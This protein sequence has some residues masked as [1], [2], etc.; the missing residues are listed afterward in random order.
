MEGAESVGWFSVFLGWII[1][2]VQGAMG[3]LW[4]LLTIQNLAT[5]VGTGFGIW[6]TW[7]AREANLYLRFER[8][9][10]RYEHQ[11]VKARSD[12]LDVMNRPGPGVLIRTPLFMTWKLRAVLQRHKWHPT[13]LWPIGQTV[14]RQLERALVTCNRK[15]SAHLGRLS[16]FREQVASARLVQGSLA[17]AR[18]AGARQLDERQRLDGEALDHFRSV[19]AIPGHQDDLGA[20]ELISHQL[21]RV[22]QRSQL[23]VSSYTRMIQILEQ[24]SASTS[25]N[26]ALARAKRCLASLIYSTSPGIA[27]RMLSDAI[28]LLTELGP[29]PDRDFLE[30]AQTYFMDGVARLRLGGN[31]QGPEQLSLAQGCYR[32]LIRSLRARRRGLFRWMMRERRYSGHRVRELRIHA[33]CGLAQVNHMI[34]L[35]DRHQALLI[36]SLRRGSGVPRHNRKPPC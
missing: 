4:Q 20:L 2:Q 10:S 18:A 31:V 1:D 29:P 27:Q 16:Y 3:K 11:L 33:E 28:E 30:L 12:L 34:R 9:I 21:A 32:E 5:M 25:R 13:S 8:M 26:R 22:D 36:A 6:K 7:E 17:A 23:A 35:N 24:H 15:V 14:D 19:L